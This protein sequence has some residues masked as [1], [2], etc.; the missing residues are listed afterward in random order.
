MG[1]E[2]PPFGGT[3]LLSYPPMPSLKKGEKMDEKWMPQ[4]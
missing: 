1:L 3:G 2:G 4:N